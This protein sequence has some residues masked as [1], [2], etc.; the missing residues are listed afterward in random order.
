[1]TPSGPALSARELLVDS[2]RRIR[3]LF[4]AVADDAPEV[5]AFRPA[6]EANTIAWLAWHLTRVQDTH[7]ADL[8]GTEPV[9]ST[10]GWVDRFD[11]DL[12]RG[13]TG[14]GATPDE[15]AAL[16]DAP[17]DL[18]VGYHAD[19]HAAT[20]AYIDSVDAAEL[21]RIVDT[22]WDPPVTASARL[23]SVI[24]DCLQHL[25]QAAYIRGLA[26]QA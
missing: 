1:M 18:L 10:A 8:A 25:G 11:L 9:W 4:D 23:V 22:D 5:L 17:A 12:G 19:V 21:A 26:E 24:G 3:D 2:F 16:D 7:V 13:A 14:Y 6:P 20:I 15:V